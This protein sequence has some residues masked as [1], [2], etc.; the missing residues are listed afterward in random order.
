MMFDDVPVVLVVAA[1]SDAVER[2]VKALIQ[3]PCFD[4]TASL[5]IALPMAR[6]RSLTSDVHASN[7]T[8]IGM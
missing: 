6:A 1:S 3:F 7:P 5:I 4:Y 2:D 8:P